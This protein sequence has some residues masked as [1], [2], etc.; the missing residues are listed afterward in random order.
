MDRK[1]LITGGKGGVGKTTVTACLGRTLALRGYRTVVMDG[2]IGLNNLDVALRAEDR[3][4][5]DIGDI[6]SG[7][8]TVAQTII[9]IEKNLYL[10]PSSTACSALVSDKAFEETANE[11]SRGFD[12]VLIDCPAGIESSFLRAAK[13]ANES[14]IVTTPHLSCVRDG[15]KT[16][17]ILSGLG[18]VTQRLLI[19]R[20]KSNLAEK[21][22]I[23]SAEEIAE[24]M[25]LPLLGVIPESLD[26]DV[27]G[28]VDTEKKSAALVS[29]GLVADCLTGRGNAVYDYIKNGKGING[30]FRRIKDIL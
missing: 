13:C 19:N 2:D 20:M 11:L 28:I 30:F 12:F 26:I 8:A 9:R 7:K 25:K 3:I 10:L 21:N 27:G 29:Y 16:S 24:A 4:L 1:I 15:Y 18:Y 14:I 6:A 5:Y 17:K 22:K 23:L